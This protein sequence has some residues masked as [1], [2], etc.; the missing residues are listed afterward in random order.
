[1]ELRLRHLKEA[2]KELEVEYSFESKKMHNLPPSLDLISDDIAIALN[3]IEWICEEHKVPHVGKLLKDVRAMMNRQLREA[4]ASLEA[5][6]KSGFHKLEKAEEEV[7]RKL[8]T[9]KAQEKSEQHVKKLLA[10]QE[11]SSDGQ[12]QSEYCTGS[13]KKTQDPTKKTLSVRETFSLTTSFFAEMTAV[14]LGCEVVRIF[15]YD[16]YENLKCCARF[17][18]D[19]T[20]GDPMEGTDM[21]LM[22]AR[23]I[24]RTVCRKGVAVNGREPQSLMI[25]ERERDLLEEELKTSGWKSMTSC[26][27]F[28]IFSTQGCRRSYGM[29]HAVNKQGISPDRPGTFDENDEVFV[30]VTARLLGCLLTRYPVGYFTQPIGQRLLQH[31][32]S[33]LTQKDSQR[34]LPPLLLD[35]VEEASEIGNKANQMGTRVLLYRAPINAIYQTRLARRKARK[36]EAL[37]MVDKSLSTVEFDLD[38]LEELWQVA[39]EENTVMYRQCQSLNEQVNM[40]QI[41]LRNILDGIGASRTLG[42]MREMTNYL[43]VLEF[44]ARQENIPMLTELISKVLL[45]ARA[46]IDV[47]QELEGVDPGHISFNEL[48]GIERRIAQTPSKLKFGAAAPPNVRTYACDPQRRRDQV[49]FFDELAK[50]REMD[51]AVGAEPVVSQRYLRE[52]S[53]A[54]AKKVDHSVS[55]LVHFGP[56]DYA[57]KRLFRLKKS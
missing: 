15:L 3:E 29:I 26:L 40:L 39:H 37:N 49:R 41:L 5:G 17:P 25:S 24:H 4:Y 50:R 11:I 7:R 48:V 18:V 32:G 8:E 21:E 44:H 43:Q 20:H 36:L 16:E 1:M 10:E 53:A 54:R 33:F 35:E 55:T 57:A 14:L 56:T 51:S 45:N 19:S 47:P 2:Q 23:E 31:L 13:Q 28:P 22:L 42:T 46:E 27:I 6:Y 52:T 38:A 34:H 9:K 30:S 12:M